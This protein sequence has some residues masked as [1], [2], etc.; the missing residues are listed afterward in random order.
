VQTAAA[1]SPPSISWVICRWARL[2]LV[3]GAI[4]TG[5]GGSSLAVDI[6]AA[7]IILMN[8][9]HAC[10]RSGDAHHI[11]ICQPDLHPREDD[12]NESC[13]RSVYDG[14]DCPVGQEEKQPD[15]CE[16]HQHVAK[17]RPP[18]QNAWT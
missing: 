14:P 18:H 12:A 10:T 17:G 3:L 15:D 1:Y 11:A 5:E 8:V 16:Q 7:A 6:G 4:A 2:A 13:V 9:A